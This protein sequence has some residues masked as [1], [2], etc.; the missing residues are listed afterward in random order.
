MQLGVIGL[1]TMGANLARNAAR[2]GAKV[3][4]FNRTTEK[5]NAFM[6][7][8]GSEGNFVPCTTPEELVKN[9]KAPRAI[10]LMVNA[11]KPVDEVIGALVPLLSKKHIIIHAGARSSVKMVHSGIEYSDMQL[12]AEAFGLLSSLHPGLSNDELAA[13]F[14]EWNQ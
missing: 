7:A 13:T 10:L 4:L 9:L 6:K 3:A 12:V 8:Y 2:K 5:M 1:G 14:E 11:G